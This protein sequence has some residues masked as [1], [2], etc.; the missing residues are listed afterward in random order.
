MSKVTPADLVPL[1]HLRSLFF[2]DEQSFTSLFN[3]VADKNLRVIVNMV[4]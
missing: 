4:Y 1:E 2:P 3:Q